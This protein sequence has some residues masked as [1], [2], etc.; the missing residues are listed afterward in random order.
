[1]SFEDD[2]E[3]PWPTFLARCSSVFL[4]KTMLMLR[5]VSKKP[6]EHYIMLKCGGSVILWTSSWLETIAFLC[7][8]NGFSLSIKQRIVTI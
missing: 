2:L 8:T 4:R 6:I 7:L 3:K 1:M 5:S